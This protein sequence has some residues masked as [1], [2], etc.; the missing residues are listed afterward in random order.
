MG[1]GG[2]GGGGGDGMS[3]GLMGLAY[4][5]MASNQRRLGYESVMFSL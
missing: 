1:G 5:S 3:S 2:G 4:A